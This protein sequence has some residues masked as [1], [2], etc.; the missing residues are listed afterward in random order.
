M[1]SQVKRRIVFGLTTGGLLATGGA[2]F[3]HADASSA[4]SGDSGTTTAGSPGILSGNTIQIPVDIPINVCGVTANVIGL[5]NPAAGNHCSNDGGA[6]ASGA[7]QGTGGATATGRSVGSP[8]ILSGNTIQAPVHIPVNAC[9]DSVNVVGVGNSAK[10]NHCR[11]GG[12]A[13]TGSGSGGGA[14]ATGSSVGSPGILSGNTIQVPVDVPVNLCGDTV[15]VVGVGNS[16]KGNHC[17]NSGGSS[18][19]GSTA[20]GSSVGSP[21]ILSGNTVQLPISVPVNAC[22]DSVNVV[23]VGN[24]AEGDSCANNTPSTPPTTTTPPPTTS[25][26]GGWVAPHTTGAETG[27]AIPAAATG[28]LAHTGADALMLAPIGAALMGG[29]AFMYRKFKPSRSH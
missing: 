9:G 6:T 17:H 21:G 11:N 18:T 26:P 10:D 22:G 14:T 7:D 3:A 19:G 24:G 2:G 1:Q 23:G 28:M 20:T 4:G 13:T 8:G 29:G 15:N 25:T 12:G 27:G 16:A 5:L